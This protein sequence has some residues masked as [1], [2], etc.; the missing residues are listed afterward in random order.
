MAADF[1]GNL[2]HRQLLVSH[3][4]TV[5]LQAK[6][7]RGY[8]RGVKVWHLIVNG[9]KFLVLSYDGVLRVRIVVDG[10]VGC[11]LTQC[12][13]L[14]PTEYIL[15]EGGREGGKVHGEREDVAGMDEWIREN[16]RFSA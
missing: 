10:R 15:G 14:Y 4:L 7:P 13:V 11:H 1:L 3:P 8:P 12:G 16:L 5:K 2:L 6:E 9:H